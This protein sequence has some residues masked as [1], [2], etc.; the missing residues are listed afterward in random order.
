MKFIKGS[1]TLTAQDLEILE[2]MEV[3]CLMSGMVR[4]NKSRV[5]RAALQHLYS[6]EKRERLK[7][8]AS[9][10]VGKPGRPKAIRKSWKGIRIDANDGAV[11][12][13]EPCRNFDQG[14]ANLKYQMGPGRN[15]KTSG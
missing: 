4:T 7:A 9:V 10:M 14:G 13:T 8:V 11:P 12:A 15:I 2:G 3:E 1:Y 5:L 6:L